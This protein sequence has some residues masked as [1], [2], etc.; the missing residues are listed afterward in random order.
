MPPVRHKLSI[1]GRSSSWAGSAI[2]LHI[3]SRGVDDR[4]DHPGDR[5]A[6]VSAELAD[7]SVAEDDLV[8]AGRA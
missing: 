4:G 1:Q 3:R 5:D 6:D 2:G 8:F 7:G